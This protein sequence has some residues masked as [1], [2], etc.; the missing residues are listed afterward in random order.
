MRILDSF[1]LFYIDTDAPAQ[2]QAD[3]LLGAL[4]Q[5]RGA[6]DVLPGHQVQQEQHSTIGEMVLELPVSSPVGDP[7]V[8]I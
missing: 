2:G 8:T 5:L 3:V 4:S 7:V 6:Q 1:A